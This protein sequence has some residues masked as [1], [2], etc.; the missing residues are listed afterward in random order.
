MAKSNA[1]SRLE[2]RI[3]PL[4]CRLGYE[5][6]N[7][8]FEKE[9]TELYF[10]VEIDSEAGISLDDCTRVSDLLDPILDEDPPT[11]ESYRLEVSSAGVERE[12]K[13]PR[14]IEAYAGSG[15]EVEISLYAP[16]GGKKKLRGEIAEYN[17]KDDVLSL[18]TESGTLNIPRSE[19]AKIKTLFDFGEFN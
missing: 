7:I 17:E 9:G 14:H 11:E 3:T 18:L 15:T 10:R 2:E 4:I 12:L 8:S 1:V 6:W 16:R 5:V 13:K 19:C